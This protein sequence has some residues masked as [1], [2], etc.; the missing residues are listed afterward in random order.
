MKQ[1]SEML[2]LKEATSLRRELE[3]LRG[4]DTKEERDVEKARMNARISII[5]KRLEKARNG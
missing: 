5:I 1:K 2:A 3:E 4:E